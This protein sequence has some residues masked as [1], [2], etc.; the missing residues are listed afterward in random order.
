MRWEL[1]GLPLK[2]RSSLY[3]DFIFLHV[4]FAGLLNIVRGSEGMII[5]CL[6]L[7]TDQL[8]RSLGHFDEKEPSESYN[9]EP[10]IGDFTT[11]KRR[12]W[13]LRETAAREDVDRAGTLMRVSLF[14]LFNFRL[15]TI[16][17]L[18]PSRH[19]Q[20]FFLWLD[21]LVQFPMATGV[22]IGGIE[23][24]TI[25]KGRVHYGYCN[26]VGGILDRGYI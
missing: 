9:R 21:H 13:N 3:V 11:Q 20:S 2:S 18:I 12:L 16:F 10:A 17:S 19:F 6:G 1:T 5:C 23:D 14:H 25:V 26:I 22:R 15:L 8:L 4:Y 7:H 24:G